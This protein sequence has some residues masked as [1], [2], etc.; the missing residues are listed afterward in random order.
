MFDEVLE[1]VRHQP[2]AH[3]C[4]RAG[5]KAGID[6]VH[7]YTE[8]DVAYLPLLQLPLDIF[9]NEADAFEVDRVHRVDT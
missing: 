2:F 3:T 9:G 7:I 6:A 5:S 8:M 4:T 1:L